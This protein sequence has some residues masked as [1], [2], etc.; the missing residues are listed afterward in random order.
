MERQP[1]TLR[2]FDVTADETGAW[3]SGPTDSGET[4]TDKEWARLSDTD[5]HHFDTHIAWQN[6]DEITLTTP[7]RF[8]DIEWTE[9]EVAIRLRFA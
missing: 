5:T 1:I 8:D 4:T 6:G 2:I 9:T 3:L 7:N